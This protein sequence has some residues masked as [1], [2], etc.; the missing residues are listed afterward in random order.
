MGLDEADDDQQR[1]D[2]GGE[3][4]PADL[5]GGGGFVRH[6]H[7]HGGGEHEGEGDDAGHEGRQLGGTALLAVVDLG[8]VGGDR[9]EQRQPD[10]GQEPEEEDQRTGRRSEGVEERAKHV[11]SF[12]ASSPTG[13][14]TT[15]K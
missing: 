15:M 14:G 11:S 9:G 3:H 2:G 10:E 6:E 1:A 7:H 12:C 4:H 13:C 5:E 8:L